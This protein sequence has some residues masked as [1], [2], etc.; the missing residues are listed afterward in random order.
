MPISTRQRYCKRRDA[1]VT[2]VQLNLEFDGFVYSKWGAQQRCAAGDWLVDNQGECYTVNRESFAK[3]YTRV[4]AG[5]YR[6]TSE[7]WAVA[8]SESGAIVTKEGRTTYGIGD[9]LVSNSADG[10]DSYA[11]DKASFEANYEK[12]AD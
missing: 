11:V 7:V 10:S 8:A 12:V 2:A 1:L 4:S 5:R 3:T 6:K 9:Y